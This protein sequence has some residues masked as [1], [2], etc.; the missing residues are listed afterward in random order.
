[1]AINNETYIGLYRSFSSQM[2]LM[3]E[4][5]FD[6]NYFPESV[7]S[8][9]LRLCRNI[10][11]TM[12]QIILTTCPTLALA[13]TIANTLVCEQLAA[14]VNI[15]PKMSSVYQWQGD[16]ITDHEIQLLI[17]TKKDKFQQVAEKIKAL[18][19]YEVPEI[20]ALN[21]QQGDNRYLTWIDESL[22]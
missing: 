14:C 1:L 6:K 12:Y 4:M 11:V 13:Q 15:L 22:T 19:S 3:T 20:I 21:I 16:I 8:S 10:T 17:K 5:T 9:K 7:Q 18:H 2:Q